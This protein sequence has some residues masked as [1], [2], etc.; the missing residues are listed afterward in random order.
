M[1]KGQPGTVTSISH[2]FLNGTSLKSSNPHV[3][4]IFF[5]TFLISRS[6]FRLSFTLLSSVQI[7]FG[8]LFDYT[9]Y[10][11]SSFPFY[12]FAASCGTLDP[13]DDF[14]LDSFYDCTTGLERR[15]GGR[16]RKG[17]QLTPTH[18][19]THPQKA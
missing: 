6:D 10:L 7:F 18:A 1:N 13:N 2:R 9:G 15:G 19:H 14:F 8:G 3:Q 5:P 4:V 11:F 12:N 17:N 16:G